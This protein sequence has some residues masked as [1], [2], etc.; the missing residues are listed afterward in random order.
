[1]ECL[2]DNNFV[3]NMMS[4]EKN[5]GEFVT[6]THKIRNDN[7]VISCSCLIVH[8][9]V[10]VFWFSSHF[11]LMSCFLIIHFIVFVL[12]FGMLVL[13]VHLCNQRARGRCCRI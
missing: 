1:M 12:L 7:M 13:V 3:K 10:F 11:H 8:F 6:K 4:F 5:G 9:I 2:T